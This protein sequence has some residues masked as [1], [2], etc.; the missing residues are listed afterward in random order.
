MS[1]IRKNK[2]QKANITN[3]WAINC[4]RLKNF[5]QKTIDEAG[6]VPEQC[7]ELK[8]TLLSMTK[9]GHS[10]PT[11]FLIQLSDDSIPGRGYSG[12]RSSTPRILSASC[13]CIIGTTS[14]D[15]VPLAANS[16]MDGLARR[17]IVFN[18]PVRN[19]PILD[20]IKQS[21]DE[22]KEDVNNKDM[23]VYRM[24]SFYKFINYKPDIGNVL[25]LA[26]GNDGSGILKEKQSV[27]SI[28][29]KSKIIEF[30]LEY[31]K[32]HQQDI[33]RKNIIYPDDWCHKGSNV[34]K[35]EEKTCM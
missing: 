22:E 17:A 5:Y 26:E 14:S 32:Q 13:S 12:D 28:E 30:E 20:R 29:C 25:M 11:L 18:S 3:F 27:I 4:N 34:I 21:R 16:L 7:K 10:A 24:Y 9:E 1:T 19:V 8:D 6:W 31:M 35:T 33:F 15:F 2:T 23:E